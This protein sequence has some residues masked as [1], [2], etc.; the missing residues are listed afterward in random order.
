MRTDLGDDP[1]VVQMSELLGIDEFAVVG[2]LHRLWS[3]ADHHTTDGQTRGINAK[4]VD[5]YV[6]HQGFAAAMIESGWLRITEDIL[7]FPKFDSHNGSSAKSRL[8]AALRQRQSRLRHTGVTNGCDRAQSIPAP[9]V[10]FVLNRDNH[11]CVYCGTAFFENDK[12]GV[13]VD[14]IKPV[15]RGGNQAVEN[16]ATACRLCNMEK[17][18][19]TPE[20][21]DLLPT[22]LQPGVHYENG[23]IMSQQS[24]T[25]P[26]PEKIREDKREKS[27]AAPKSPPP[28]DDLEWMTELRDDPAYKGID[29][30][31]EHAKAVRWCKENRRQ[32]T[33]KFF[34][35]WLNKADRHLDVKF[36]PSSTTLKVVPPP[37]PELTDEQI[38]KNKAVIAEHMEKL[39]ARMAVK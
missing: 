9:F 39:T 1:A 5:R 28:A 2:R 14:H 15:S 16:L 32:L 6:N 21:W 7:K 12:R 25:S 19:R 22:F 29:V 17:S 10:R 38:A 30:A 24:V 35:N 33:R 8:D 18:D 26:L 36:K 23:Q 3:W 4:W 20:E 27:T 11:T 34:I 37:P 13:S 31:R